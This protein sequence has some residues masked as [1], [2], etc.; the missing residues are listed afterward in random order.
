[1]RARIR[2][3]DLGG[4]PLYDPRLAAAVVR[5]GAVQL[6]HRVQ[7][8][9][10]AHLGLP[11]PRTWRDLT[12]PRYRGWIVMADPTHELL[13]A[14]AAYMMVV[15]RAMADAPQQGRSEDD[16][17]ADGMGLL[18]QIAANARLF[19]DAELG[20]CPA[21][22]RSG[23]VAA[24]MTIDFHCPDRRSTRSR[25]EADGRTSS[26]STRRP[27][28]P[29]RSP[30]RRRRGRVNPD[31]HPVHRVRPQRGR[32]AA[33][34]HAR[35]HARRA[36]PSSLCSGCRSR[37]RLYETDPTFHR[38]GQ[39]V[40]SAAE[41]STRPA[42]ARS[43]FRILGEMIQMSMM[44]V[45]E[46]LRETRR[47]DP[48]IAPRCGA[49]RAARPFPVRPDRSPPPRRSSGTSAKPVDRL[50]LQRQ[51]TERIPRGVSGGS[52]QEARTCGASHAM[53]RLRHY[54]SSSPL[55]PRRRSACF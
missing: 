14:K 4:L 38:Q 48:R 26:R 1:M 25:H 33:L 15:E 27:S 41:G 30:S 42:R 20:A 40:H 32:A 12:D 49:R 37:R 54:A 3:A 46:D 35:G 19:T 31:G 28:T 11:E 45:L 6:R 7:P 39:P 18:R 22:S 50:A 9:V 51:W 52:A 24:G 34:E 13:G 55:H 21:R 29:T 2:S 17:W 5:H 10:V 16:G 44:D 23:D 36:A 8:D 43:T 53:T 47:I